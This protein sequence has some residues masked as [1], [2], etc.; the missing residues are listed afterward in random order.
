MGRCDK[1]RLA[2]Q[3]TCIKR[4]APPTDCTCITDIGTASSDTL[5]SVPEVVRLIESNQDSFYV[6]DPKD[7]SKAYVQIAQRGGRK[8]IRT[9]ANDTPDDNLLKL[10]DCH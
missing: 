8:Y 1:N 5:I 10:S 2:R 9:R 7:G 6:V 4:N 3:I